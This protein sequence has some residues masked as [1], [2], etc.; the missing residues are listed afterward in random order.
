[1]AKKT[2]KKVD[3]KKVEKMAVK[4][5]IQ[6]L[7]EG[8]GFVVN[9]GKE[10]YGFTDGTLVVSMDKCDIQIKLIAPKAGIDRYE[11]LEEELEEEEE[12]VNSQENPKE[13]ETGE[14]QEVPKEEVIPN[15]EEVPV[16][17]N[18]EEIIQ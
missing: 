5:N 1:M 6:E 11:K 4:G 17:G 2:V 9:D 7:F 14:S 12:E 13:G 3:C 8:L 15:E 18:E 10:I 16:N